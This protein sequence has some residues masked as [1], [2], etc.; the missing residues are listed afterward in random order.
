MEKDIGRI[1]IDREENWLRVKENVMAASR[2]AMAKRL[3]GN[4]A[5]R[6]EVEQRMKKVSLSTLHP[7]LEAALADRRGRSW[8]TPSQ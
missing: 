7:R 4:E 3:A 5:L 6:K 8:R 1:N 2:E